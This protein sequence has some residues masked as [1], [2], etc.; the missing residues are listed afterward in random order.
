MSGAMR[1]IPA[2]ND[3]A[4]LVE[5]SRKGDRDAFARIVERYQ[6]LVC[7]L[8][9]S[10]SGNVQASEDLAQVT[11][12]TAW[13][14]LKQLRE[15]EKLKSWLCRIARN[16]ATDSHRQQQRTPTANAEELDAN[17]AEPET[18][19]DRVISAEEQA[20]LWRVLQDMPETYRELLVLFY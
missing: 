4:Q 11:F 2:I 10:A 9:Y 13:S 18:P 20:I 1:T 6:S 14:Q 17:L 16:V 19:R 5:L 7:A 15:P 3:D 12:I 8:T